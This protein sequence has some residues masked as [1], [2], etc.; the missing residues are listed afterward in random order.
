M[1]NH[2][3]NYVNGSGSKENLARLKSIVDALIDKETSTTYVECYAKIYPMFF[4][5]QIVEQEESENII[6]FDVYLEYGSKWFQGEF[7]IDV[8]DGSLTISGDSA[9]S[10]V[11]SFFIKLAVE[12]KLTLEGYYEESGMDFA[13]KFTI[14]P[15][16]ELEDTQMSY[17]Q[18]QMMENPEGFWQ[19][20]M[21]SIEE[22]YF[23]SMEEIINHF[24][25]DYWGKLTQEDLNLLEKAYKDYLANQEHDEKTL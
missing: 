22:G 18:M 11:L 20:T 14:S 3:Y 25:V 6:N 13:G 9:W 19:N 12:Y 7:E 10:P 24:E 1:A 17:N 4:P 21:D 16:G 8:E 15:T 23:D 5:Q 2:C